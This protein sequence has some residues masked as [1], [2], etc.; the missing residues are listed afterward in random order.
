MEIINNSIAK[1]E[2]ENLAI[3][4]EI[5]KFKDEYNYDKYKERGQ[6]KE[7]MKEQNVSGKMGE[8][9]VKNYFENNGIK[10]NGFDLNIYNKSQ[11]S[12]RSDLII[13]NDIK[14]HCKSTN[15][16]TAER[17]GL[18]WTFQ[19]ANK[20]GVKYNGN[21]DKE[22]FDKNNNKDLFIGTIVKD[23]IVYI[24]TIC[25]INS[26]INIFKPSIKYPESKKVIYYND[27]NKNNIIK[28]ED[29]KNGN[30]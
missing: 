12:Y 23:K 22:I 30:F 10:V 20:F 9:G 6:E 3:E 11:K 5:D 17:Y 18:S 25:K 8:L 2:I 1:I 29:I 13:L 16:I 27:I 26:L 19:W 28:M 21:T 4:K 7:I 15:F 14:I 24:M